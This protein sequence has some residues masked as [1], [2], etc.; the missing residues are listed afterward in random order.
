MESSSLN[1]KHGVRTG[2][3]INCAG[4]PFQGPQQLVFQL[5]TYFIAF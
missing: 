5:E 2:D 1:Y 3:G 4:A